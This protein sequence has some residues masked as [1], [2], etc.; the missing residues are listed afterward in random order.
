MPSTNPSRIVVLS[1]NWLGD[2]V[3]A[4]PAIADVKRHFP[5]AHLVVAARQSIAGV[6]R[7]APS[8]DEVLALEWGGKVLRLRA[9]RNDLAALRVVAADLALLFPNS[10]A[11]A[12]MVRRAAIPDRWGYATDLRRPLLSRAIRRPRRSMHQGAYYQHLVHQL[13]IAAGVL[14]PVLTAPESA[15]VEA[16]ALLA[17]RGC[18]AAGRLVVIAPGAAYG[19][20][21]RWLPAH[22]AHLVT[23][24]VNTQDATCV[25]VGNR[26]DLE[27]T[28][29]IMRLIP[30]RER[31]Q[32]HDLA[33]QTTLD[34]LAGVMSLSRVFVSND[35]GAMH[36][37]AALG[38]PV[39]A[40]FGPTRE[41][42]TAPLGRSGGRTE[43]LLQPVWCRPCMLR[44]CP[45]DHRCMRGLSPERVFVTVSELMADPK[46]PASPH[47]PVLHVRRQR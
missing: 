19:T 34:S 43:V 39:V 47:G 13:G 12:W 35:S 8:V 11:S 15:V 44:E 36:M 6:F 37:A 20:A 32:T 16:R 25:L 26:G 17:A 22:F 14:E 9:L 29:W 7:L 28:R 10:F 2:A 42:E 40:L 30:E 1:P 5:S 24:L 31:S 38:V 4:L 45:I 41:H 33:G 27:T 21:K 3:M 46:G 18:D 23:M